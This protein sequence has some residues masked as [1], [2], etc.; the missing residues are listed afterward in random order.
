MTFEPSKMSGYSSRSVSSAST[1]WMRSDHC[2]SHGRGR[3]E[4]LVPGRQLDRA[5]AGVAAER[6]GERL[7]HDPLDV[8]LRLG[9]GQPERVDLHAVAQA[10]RLRVGDAVALTPELLPE[11]AHRAQLGVLLDEADAGVDEERDPPEDRGH[12]VLRDA[13]ARRVEHRDRVAH[14]VGD[15]LHRRRAGLLQVVAADVDRVPLRD[16]LDRV[17]DHVRDQ[18]H[19]RAGREGVGPARQE[20]LDDVVLRRAAELRLVDAL[21]P[22]P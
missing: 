14:R 5:G 7:E 11:D 9:L 22:R 21:R 3:P 13:L 12:A 20:L 10:Q 15:L 17:G 18:P 8:V 4:R 19:R 2:W 1:C 6:H 16:V